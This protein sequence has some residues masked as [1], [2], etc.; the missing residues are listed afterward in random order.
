MSA[1]NIYSVTVCKHFAT[2]ESFQ[3]SERWYDGGFINEVTF[4]T[5]YL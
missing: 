5:V 1:V 2:T 3:K 4:D